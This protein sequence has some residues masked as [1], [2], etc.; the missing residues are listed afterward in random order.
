MPTADQ[1]ITS[2]GE[3]IMVDIEKCLACKACELACAEGHTEAGSILDA[4]VNDIELLP[5]VKV[6]AGGQSIPLQCRHCKEAPCVAACPAEALYKEKE[7]GRVL[8]APEKCIACGACV[9]V[10]PYEAIYLD[11]ENETVIKCDVCEGLLQ[12]GAPPFCVSACPTG[13]LRVGT[14]EEMHEKAEKYEELV[15]DESRLRNAGPG[16][17]FEID[18]D[19]CICCGRCARDCPV[20]CISG[21]AGKAPDKASESDREKGKVGEPFEI[22]QETCVR[23][24]TCLEVCPADAVIKII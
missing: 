21:K 1:K 17:K 13:S 20:D 8:S 10:C 14:V 23:C 11:E 9:R 22:D 2:E 4:I 12:E 3:A 16:V 5:R 18:S 24:G 7:G 15:R 6:I 19:S